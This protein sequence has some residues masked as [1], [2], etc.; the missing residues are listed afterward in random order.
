MNFDD[1]L[2]SQTKFF[3]CVQT[4]P[5]NLGTCSDLKEKQFSCLIEKKKLMDPL[6]DEK[7]S[8]Y[9]YNESLREEYEII[10][11]YDKENANYHSKCYSLEQISGLCNYGIYSNN[12]TNVCFEKTKEYFTKCVPEGETKFDGKKFEKCISKFPKPNTMTEMN[13]ILQNCLEEN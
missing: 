7:T 8:K 5:K 1:C 12:K 9:E 13:G 3:D 2:E 6:L 4:N 11:N 10:K